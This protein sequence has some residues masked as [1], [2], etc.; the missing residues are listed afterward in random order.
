MEKNM[1]LNDK[2]LYQSKGGHASLYSTYLLNGIVCTLCFIA[3]LTDNARLTLLLRFGRPGLAI[4]WLFFLLDALIV[5]GICNLYLSKFVI[6]DSRIEGTPFSLFRST[7]IT[8]ARD[9]IVSVEMDKSKGFLILHTATGKQKF[10]CKNVQI[11][12][13]I[14]M[15]A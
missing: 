4:P 11:A 7:S 9:Q 3:L 2:I 14:L 5:C 15:Q 8:M 6:Y 12:Y 10:P 1:P 13:N